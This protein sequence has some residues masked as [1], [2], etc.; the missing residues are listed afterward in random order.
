MD[1]GSVPVA[2][3]EG[4]ILAHSLRVGGAVFRKGRVLSASDV[5]ELEKAG[6][7][8]VTIARLAAMDVSENLAAERIARAIAG[9]GVAVGASFTGRANLYAQSAGLVC[10]ADETVARLN[11][12]DEAITLATLSPFERVEARQMIA[13]VKIIPFAAPADAVARAEQLVSGQ[14]PI[15]VAPFS[16]KR[17]ALISTTTTGMKPS[18]LDK[19]RSALDGRLKPL[20]SSIVFEERV[21]HRID[22]LAKAIRAAHATGSNPILVFGG[23]RHHRTATLAPGLPRLWRQAA[24]SIISECRS[25]PAIC[26]CWAISEKSS[27]LAC[28]AARVRPS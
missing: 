4:G 19:N 5:A 27:S 26:F 13:T 20:G 28:P 10:I 23:E 24:R 16:P 21:A 2:S 3:A 17:A 8:E 14:P 6:Y 18:L 25:T 9:R 1:F 15:A 12:V 22:D 11:A 7:E